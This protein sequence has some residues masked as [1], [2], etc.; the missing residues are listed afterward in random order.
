[1]VEHTPPI[2][3][4]EEKATTTTIMKERKRPLFRRHLWLPAK[5]LCQYQIA[6][7]V[8]CSLGGTYVT[9]LSLVIG[10]LVYSSHLVPGDRQG[11]NLL[12]IPE[13]K[14]ESPG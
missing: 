10:L 1:M 8:Y 14:L 5:V 13:R 7:L 6:T 3:A 12:S 11:K 2:L 4:R 9:A